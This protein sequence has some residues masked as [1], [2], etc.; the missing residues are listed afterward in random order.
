MR[1]SA[2]CRSIY[3]RGA[4]LRGVVLEG[5]DLRAAQLPRLRAGALDL[6]DS[7]L[8]GAAFASAR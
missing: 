6:E 1:R 7:D 4:I 8:R 3:R 5:A 2:A